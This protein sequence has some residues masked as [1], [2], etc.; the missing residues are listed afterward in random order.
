LFCNKATQLCQ[1]NPK[2]VVTCPTVDDT[3]C[4]QNL[5]QPTNGLCQMTAIAEKLP[6]DDG[7]ICTVGEVC[8]QGTCTASADTC[9]CNQDSDCTVQDDGNLCNG[10]LYCDLGSGQCKLNPVTIVSCPSVSDTVC[11]Q[12]QCVAKTGDCV[13]TANQDGL[14]CEDGNPCTEGEACLDG[15]C[16]GTLVCACQEDSDC[17]GQE[18]GNQCNGTLYCNKKQGKCEVNPATVKVCPTASDTPCEQTVCEPASGSCVKQEAFTGAKCDADGNPCTANDYCDAGSCKPGNNACECLLDSDCAGK[19]GADQCVTSMFCNPETRS[20]EP[21]QVVTCDSSG[22]TPCQ[23]NACN[24]A[25]GKCEQVTKADGILCGEGGLCSGVLLCDGGACTAGPPVNCS[26]A[27][28]CTLDQ[29]DPKLGCVYSA[30]TSTEGNLAVCDDGSVCTSADACVA[31]NCVGTSTDC[32]DGSPC[33]NDACDPKAGCVY[34]PSTA[35]V[36]DDGNSCTSGDF[37]ASGACK[38][39]SAAL[40]CDDGLPCTA[41]SCDPVQGCVFVGI[42]DKAC[43]DGTACTKNDKCVQG[44]CLGADIECD[45]DEVCTKDS[46]DE[47]TGCQNVAQAGAVCSDNNACTGNDACTKQGLCKA[48]PV[49]VCN[50]GNPCTAD[51]CD[52]LQGCVHPALTGGVAC[53]DGDAC[54]NQ[55]KCGT[56]GCKGNQIGCDD[57]KACTLDSC[58]SNDGC[59][60]L[61]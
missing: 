19:Q 4:A 15:A 22:D 12:N 43:D 24:P 56:S 50:D 53:N 9:Q 17:V 51:E 3:T 21:A 46:C 41:D 10:T 59:V 30:L 6:C 40:P 55:D 28:P 39:G 54:T 38:S 57:A 13:M 37:C 34:L 47:V 16:K 31:G 18:D 33:T 35:T 48:G 11:A 52:P 42:S 27:D 1:L 20:C 45:D 23:K 5:C 32:S 61:P 44:Q 49:L 58:D 26:D 2:T 7:N 14:G 8:L 60:N 29:C 36:C 25:S